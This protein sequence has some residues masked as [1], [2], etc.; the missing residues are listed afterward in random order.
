VDSKFGNFWGGWCS[1]KL[2]GSFGVG[3]WKNIRKGWETFSSFFRFEVG[4]GVTA[5]FWHD[6]WCGILFL[7]NLF[8]CLFG[9]ACAKDAS[10]VANLE[11]LGDSNQ[12]NVSFSKEA[13]DW[14]AD[15]FASF[16]QILHSIIVRRD[17]EYRLWWVSSKRGLFKVKSLFRSLACSDGSRFP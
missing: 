2:V 10:I 14:E 16:F 7:R 9:I 4:D 3:L 13:H 8:L 17:S 15:V 5:K 1:P 6:L 12:W 11:L